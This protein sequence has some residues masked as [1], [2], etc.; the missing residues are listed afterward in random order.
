MRGL[1]RGEGGFDLGSETPA[2]ELRL[3][4]LHRLL[5]DGEA[6]IGAHRPRR[7][8]RRGRWPSAR[9]LLLDRGH[10]LRGLGAA[11]SGAVTASMRSR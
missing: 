5:V 11:G 10:Q 9:D 1:E 4:G 8:R 3:D 6:D 7:R 2:E